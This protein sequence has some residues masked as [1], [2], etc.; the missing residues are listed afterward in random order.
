MLSLFVGSVINGMLYFLQSFKGLDQLLE[1]DSK[2]ELL[3]LLAKEE[4]ALIVLDYTLF[5]F[6]GLED[7]INIGV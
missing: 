6:T 7:L 3:Q 2:K 1:A 5:D 4:Q